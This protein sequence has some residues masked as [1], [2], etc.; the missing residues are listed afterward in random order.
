VIVLSILGVA[1]VLGGEVL[2]MTRENFRKRLSRARHDLESFMD[3]QCGLVDPANPCR[4]AKKT[5]AFIEAG[6]VDP[7]RLKF[8]AR[9]VRSVQSVVPET[10]KALETW[11]RVFREQPMHEGPDIAAS[12]HR[13]VDE[14]G[15]AS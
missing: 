4:C 2:G 13:F 9:H 12:L 1:D 7:G 11:L 15:G 6:V 10:T 8:V 5:R 14:I 3:N